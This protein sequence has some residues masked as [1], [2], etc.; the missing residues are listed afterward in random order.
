MA[1]GTDFHVNG[2][3]GGARLELVPAGAH[4][5]EGAVDGMKIGLHC[6]LLFQV[7]REIY[8]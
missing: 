4:D 5:G 3:R 8:P 6:I 2:S 1:L 7:S